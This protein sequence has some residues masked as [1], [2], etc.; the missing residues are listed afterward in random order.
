VA[1]K[2]SKTLPPPALPRPWGVSLPLPVTPITAANA[3][4]VAPLACWGWGGYHL[5]WS[6][7]A[8]WLAITTGTGVHIFAAATLTEVALEVGNFGG[9]YWANDGH[10]LA[11]TRGS[12]I[13]LWHWDGTRLNRGKTLKGGSGD[14]ADVVFSRDGAL[15]A[16][17][18]D[19]GCKADLWRVGDG[20]HLRTLDSPA[21]SINELALS[22]DGG[23]LA[24][25]CSR[26]T[27]ARPPI[28]LVPVTGEA[29]VRQ[30]PVKDLLPDDIGFTPDGALLL[31]STNYSSNV[32]GWE[33]ATGRAVT[34]EELAALRV[35]PGVRLTDAVA[36]GPDGALMVAVSNKGVRIQH[37][38]SKQVALPLRGNWDE[39][40]VTFAPDA[41]ALAVQGNSGVLRIIRLDSGTEQVHRE[42]AFGRIGA[43]AVAPDGA[44]VAVIGDQQS[45]HFLRLWRLADG[46]LIGSARDSGSRA[47]TVTFTPD[48]V[49]LI[50]ATW[51]G[52]VTFRAVPSLDVIDTL[53]D[54]PVSRLAIS[55]DGLV[56]AVGLHTGELQIWDMR[57]RTIRTTVKAH[58]DTVGAVSFLPDGQTILTAGTD[59]WGRLW[60]ADDGAPVAKLKHNRQVFTGAASP[61]GKLVAT[62]CRDK[63]IYLWNARDG[64]PLRTI[65]AGRSAVQTLAWSPGGDVLA[66]A[67]V[68][69]TVQLWNPATG[70]L[71]ATLKGHRGDVDG[72]AF[73]QTGSFLISGSADGTLRLWGL[74]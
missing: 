11:S 12:A 4:Q 23:F 40:G 6:P 58:K 33:V 25:L 31:A 71:L 45:N 43:V 32:R 16:A 62:G 10:L 24:L 68:G 15:L 35:P 46:N 55:P 17:I 47:D 59:L 34:S 9:T 18:S 36:S 52:G 57:T 1:R 30:F 29:P 41:S 21:G 20:T 54:S 70:D 51:K 73:H 74:V 5:G 2:S 56:L 66:S 37:P 67:S 14:K 64:S 65:A 53:P 22:P 49:Q 7:D 69:A 39:L 44:S 50:A 19:R 28:Y 26:V 63:C 60:R 8:S 42:S 27:S 61:D 3:A 72:L 48:G 38:N 13:Q